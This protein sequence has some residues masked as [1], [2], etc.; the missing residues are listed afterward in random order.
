M[1]K[2][3]MFAGSAGQAV[4]WERLQVLGHP[5]NTVRLK[6][7]PAATTKPLETIGQTAWPCAE[8]FATA[9]CCAP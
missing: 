3:P 8:P 7:T 5:C 9:S 4:S 1:R 6:P 2:G